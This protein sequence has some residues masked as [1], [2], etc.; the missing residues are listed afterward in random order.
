MTNPFNNSGENSSASPFN[1]PHS[2]QPAGSPGARYGGY[3]DTNGGYA[4]YQGYGGYH[5]DQS[6]AAKTGSFDAMESL[7]QAWKIFMEN[8]VPWIVGTLVYGCLAAI[9]ML[10][11]M[12]SVIVVAINADSD[13][14][15]VPVFPMGGV[16]VGIVILVVAISFL[17]L[18]IFRNARQVIGGQSVTVADFF[19]FHGI[20]KMFVVALLLG[21]AVQIG[22]TVVIG[23]FIVSFFGM[24][25]VAASAD[26]HTS[27]IS[28]FQKSF[29]IILA[30][31]AQ[32]ILLFIISSLVAV[33]GFL[34]LGVGALVTVPVSYIAIAHAF[35]RASNAPVM[36][37][38]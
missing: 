26:P 37:R 31:F 13:P 10:I 6:Q 3:Q 4:G 9:P 14:D 20:G 32:A 22:G 5:N 25:A 36:Q 1:A 21:I 24:F 23:S 15:S 18:L 12:F 7:G 30:N 2:G 29:D 19:A 28:S 33:V 17:Q 11:G 35:A 38:A 34:I 27:I 8:P 16:F